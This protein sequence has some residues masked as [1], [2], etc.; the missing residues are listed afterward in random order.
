MP[1]ASIGVAAAFATASRAAPRKV[2]RPGPS[3]A[4]TK[5]GLVQNCP[6]PIVS[7][8]TNAAPR[9]APRD[10]K[11]PSSRNTGLIEL[12]S[13]YTGIGSGRLAA[14]ATRAV[15]AVRDPVKPTALIRGS[16]TSAT[17]SSGPDP[18]SSEKVPA[19]SPVSATASVMAR[20]INSEVPGWASWALTTTGHPAA[21]AEAVS[22][23]A[24]ENASGKLLAPNT[25]TGPRGIER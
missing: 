15:P 8:A 19:G 18:N 12:I 10:V 20:P 24:T 25:A 16:V 13:A 21:S 7:D 4:I 11:A 23:P 17:P 2:S 3:M 6:E 22:P 14:A 5:P 9:A 1:G